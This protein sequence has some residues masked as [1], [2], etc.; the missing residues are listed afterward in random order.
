MYKTI[1]LL[2]SLTI[3]IGCSQPKVEKKVKV[4][5]PNK[6][7]KKDVLPKKFIPK[8]ILLSHIEVVPH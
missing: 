1:I 3:L 2:A 6:T 7:S 8:H 4:V 5:D